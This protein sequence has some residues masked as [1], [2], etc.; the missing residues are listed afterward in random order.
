[1]STL[2]HFKKIILLHFTKLIFGKKS[3][4]VVRIPSTA[5]LKIPPVSQNGT[6]AQILKLKWFKTGNDAR[7]I[8][9]SSN[10]ISS[11]FKCINS[12]CSYRSGRSVGP[13]VTRNC[14]RMGFRKRLNL[15]ILLT[16]QGREGRGAQIDRFTFYP[17]V[18]RLLW[19]IKKKQNN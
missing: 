8:W 3:G 7:N 2:N 6:L 12:N 18:K 15:Q 13:C 5:I 4:T 10:E 1:M 16:L 14:W 17:V 9:R 11:C 19:Q